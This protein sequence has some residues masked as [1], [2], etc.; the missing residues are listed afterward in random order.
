MELHDCALAVRFSGDAK[1]DEGPVVATT[2]GLGRES[3]EASSAG[4]ETRDRKEVELGLL[5][6]ERKYEA[7][8]CPVAEGT[9]LANV[10]QSMGLTVEIRTPEG[11]DGP[12]VTCVLI[13]PRAGEL[14]HFFSADFV[15]TSGAIK[16]RAF[17]IAGKVVSSEKGVHHQP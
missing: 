2:A 3:A 5:K 11:A 7:T 16:H 8:I 10:Q 15:D 6:P 14:L 9:T 1:V 12:A 13:T 17:S 4:E